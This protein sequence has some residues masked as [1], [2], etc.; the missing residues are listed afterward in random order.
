MTTN[1]ADYHSNGEPQQK[2]YSH[3]NE[4]LKHI[5]SKLENNDYLLIKERTAVCSSIFS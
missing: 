5:L 2:K 1:N 3:V 4:E